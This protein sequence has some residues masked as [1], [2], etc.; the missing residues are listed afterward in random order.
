MSVLF[1]I[2]ANI[3]ARKMEK[4][5]AKR[6]KNE[7][8]KH[9]IN[10]ENLFIDFFKKDYFVLYKNE[11]EIKDAPLIINIHGGA[12]IYGS[13]YLNHT[14]NVYFAKQGYDVISLNYPLLQK[15][16]LKGMIQ[17]LFNAL[18][19]IVENAGDFVNVSLDRVMLCGDSAGGHLASL[20]AAINT[21]EELLKLY[22]VK[23]VD[24]DFKSL[25]LEHPCAYIKDLLPSNKKFARRQLEKA[26]FGPKLEKNPIYNYSSFNEYAKL[27]KMPRVTLITSSSD[28]FYYQAERMFEDLKKFDIRVNFRSYEGL[29]HVFEV[30]DPTLEVSK[31]VHKHAF[32]DFEDACK[33]DN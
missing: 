31:R 10:Y 19:F 11:N 9:F 33:G 18:Q 29:E 12:W 1:N 28:P 15:V 2:Y 4:D 16:D 6:P 32:T 25:Y 24:I 27:G 21:S 30:K 3:L 13:A 26:F 7:I 8:E 17:Y 5:D 14:Q 22:E 20:V 23:H